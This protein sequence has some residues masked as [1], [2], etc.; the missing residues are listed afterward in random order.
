MSTGQY[1]VFGLALLTPPVSFGSVFPFILKVESFKFKLYF[2]MYGVVNV[3]NEPAIDQAI[4]KK[5]LLK[6]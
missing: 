6:S 5:F 4:P 1:L 2:L 3:S